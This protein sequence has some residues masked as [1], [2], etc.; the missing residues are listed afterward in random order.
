MLVL[1][2]NPSSLLF[3]SSSVED[4]N[5]HAGEMSINLQKTK[6]KVGN[7]TLCTHTERERERDFIYLVK[8]Q[9]EQEGGFPTQQSYQEWRKKKEEKCVLL[10][11]E[12][13]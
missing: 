7:E 13:S 3:S 1:K 2:G 11:V 4:G 12:S 8:A 5:F 10:E 6:Q 9:K